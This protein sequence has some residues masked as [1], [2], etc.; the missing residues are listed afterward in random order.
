MYKKYFTVSFDDGL[1]QDK[2]LIA[3][4]KKY[5]IKGTFNINGGLLGERGTVKRIGN[6]AFQD[7]GEGRTSG[8]IIKYTEHNRIP[9]DEIA[10]VYAGMEIASHSY[11]HDWLGKLPKQEMMKSINMD[12]DALE[13]IA[14]Y[15]IRGHAYAKGSTSK[16]VQAYLKKEG[17]LY[18]RGIMSS[19]SFCFPKNPLNLRP[20]CSHITK[21][22]RINGLIDQFIKA[23][24]LKEDMLF[25]MWG[26]AYELDFNT[27]EASWD[28]IERLFDRI[29]GKED[30]LYCTNAEAFTAHNN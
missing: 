8:A 15:K 26:H 21:E 18:A 3:L 12:I 11:M 2:K 14:G 17:I 10:Q 25:Y 5:G 13:K 4:M 9:G 16:E 28:K 27:K 6:L 24:P 29:A 22:A 30:I 20:T 19:K 23:K 7:C 1:E